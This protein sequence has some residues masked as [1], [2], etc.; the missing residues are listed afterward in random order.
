[1]KIRKISVA[2]IFIFFFAIIGWDIFAF[3]AEENSTFSVII[4][5]WYYANQWI[6]ILISTFMGI[7][8]GHWFMPSLGS[9]D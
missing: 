8:I 5:D 7:L 6:G 3:N 4:T 9:K 2:L 1:M